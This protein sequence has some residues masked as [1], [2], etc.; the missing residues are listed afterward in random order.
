MSLP[1]AAFG[2]VA[3]FASG[4]LGFRGS[5][6]SSN[7]MDAN[8]Q[9]QTTLQNGLEQNSDEMEM[10]NAECEQLIIDSKSHHLEHIEDGLTTMP[11]ASE[12]TDSKIR[13]ECSGHINEEDVQSFQNRVQVSTGEY[14]TGSMPTHMKL[15]SDQMH[16]LSFSG[17]YDQFKHFDS[18]KD[19]LDHNF[20][21]ETA[22][23]SNDRK[24]SKKV[25]QEWSILEKNLPDMIYAPPTVYYHSHGL[26]LNPNLYETG[27]VCLSLLNTWTGRG[28][29]I[30]DP[31][32]SSILQVLIS[33]QGLVLN[34]RPYF[35][36]AGYDK[37]VGTTEG[38]KNSVA[39]NEN[40]F[41]L[42]CK[43]ML[44]L[45]HRP[46]QHFESFV[47]DHFRRRSQSILAACD[48][49]MKGAEVGSLSEVP[50]NSDSVSENNS[51]VGFRLML[52]KV[53]P[54]LQAAFNEL[55]RD[56]HQNLE[57]TLKEVEDREHTEA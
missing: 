20:L 2:F 3:R 57:T 53:M 47:K 17:K 43:L 23:S 56:D 5:K 10:S 27:K 12:V 31:K 14:S 18:V 42:A 30:W 32:I 7:T 54:K 15:N 45:L 9:E 35:N 46:P 6:S 25:Q 51:S 19:P 1:R 37:Q 26:K 39:Y 8:S 16:S 36:E 22:Q 33:L 34:A 55:S 4:L 24:W 40:S 41:L 28:N 48:A 52:A 11:I 29:E 49:Y 21:N 44:Y 13:V 50:L 38:E